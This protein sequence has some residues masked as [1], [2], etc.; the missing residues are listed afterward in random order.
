MNLKIS[1]NDLLKTLQIGA[2][3]LPSKPVYPVLSDYL[4][5]VKD[6][7]LK[8][9]TTD[10]EYT[11]IVESQI[12]S[13]DGEFVFPG[14]LLLSTV[15]EMP[16]QPIELVHDEK[17][18]SLSIVSSYGNYK[19]SSN[20]VTDYPTILDVSG[21]EYKVNSGKFVK[22]LSTC[23]FAA[24][25]DEMKTNMLGINVSFLE[26]K[27]VFAATDAH[28]L[29]KYTLNADN[30]N[31]GQSFTLPKKTVSILKSIVGSEGE[32]IITQSSNMVMFAYKNYKVYCKLMDVKFPNYNAVIPIN[33]NKD[34]IIDRTELIRSLKRIAVYGNRD[35]YQTSFKI[36]SNEL[37][38]NAL[39]ADYS[40]DAN[41]TLPCHY[42][43]DEFNVNYNA[44]YLI[45]S[46][47]N[48][49][50]K[51]VKLSFSEPNRAGVLTP[52]EE[53]NTR[54]VIM[55]VMPVMNKRID[56]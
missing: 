42:S 31:G 32:L 44:K 52:I 23:L 43:G 40:T 56:D 55:L 25:T 12:D 1:S 41:E 33:N 18:D 27:I 28:K 47:S 24:A 13:K 2:M 37:K 14:E 5:E 15:K 36:G 10:L 49:D 30:D 54:E 22:A 50:S 16:D 9:T 48:L 29:V 20:K 3:V 45:D 11:I 34:V 4:F 19:S 21:T 6:N 51:D 35:T 7:V 38:I 46:L 26:D 17:T 53:D 39:D 8:V